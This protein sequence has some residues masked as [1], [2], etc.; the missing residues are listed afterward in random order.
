M[1]LPAAPVVNAVVMVMMVAVM[2]TMVLIL[3]AL[4]VDLM[5]MELDL[6]VMVVYWL[7][8]EQSV[9]TSRLRVL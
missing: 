5:V 8:Q 2:L 7:T 4:E 6:V 1:A 9:R 3:A